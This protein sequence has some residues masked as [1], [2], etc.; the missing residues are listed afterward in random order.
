MRDDVLKVRLLKLSASSAVDRS[1]TLPCRYE[2]SIFESEL[3]FT[4]L[5]IKSEINAIN[6]D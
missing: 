5:V 4:R 2:T 1:L 6:A 3:C